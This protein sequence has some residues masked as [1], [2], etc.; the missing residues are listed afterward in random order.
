MKSVLRIVV[1]GTLAL[2]LASC[3]G[4]GGGTAG[5]QNLVNGKTFTMVLPAD[6][7][8]LDPHFTSLSV[9]HQVDRFL[10]DQLVNID[11]D[12]KLVAGLAEKWEATTTKA[13]FTLRKAITCSDGSPL[14]AT[15]VANNISF[16][17][18]PKNASSRMGVWVPPGATA[19]RQGRSGDRSRS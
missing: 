3:G 19:V 2:S 7:G 1:A 14:T 6:P 5:S 9:T 11:Q 16:V 18:D 8:N 13:T 10:Y 12:G 17:G 4:E 15:T